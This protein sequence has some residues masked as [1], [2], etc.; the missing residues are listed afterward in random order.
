MTLYYNEG[1][2]RISLTKISLVHLYCSGDKTHQNTWLKKG[3]K[4]LITSRGMLYMLCIA[5]RSV[6]ICKLG[7]QTTAP[8]AHGTIQKSQ[9]IQRRFSC[10]FPSEGKETLIWAYTFLT[11]GRDWGRWSTLWLMNES[12]LEWTNE[13]LTCD[14]D[15]HTQRE[16]TSQVTTSKV[17]QPYQ[18][19]KTGLSH[20]MLRIEKALWMRGETPSK[21]K[22]RSDAFN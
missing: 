7:R 21:L 18:R 5:V 16:S 3:T 17:Q 4:Y 19:M 14:P 6:Q 2:S 13:H 15:I 11:E 8:R 9:L 1:A 22:R 12:Q 20:Q 10:A